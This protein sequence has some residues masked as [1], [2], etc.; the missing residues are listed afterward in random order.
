M[1]TADDYRLYELWIGIFM[2][3][4]ANNDNLAAEGKP[5][6]FSRLSEQNPIIKSD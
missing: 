1:R 2:T 6:V 4:I 3:D 5:Y